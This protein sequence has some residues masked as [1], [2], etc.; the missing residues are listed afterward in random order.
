[1]TLI[2]W[3]W[4]SQRFFSSKFRL[5]CLIRL[6]WHHSVRVIAGN[7][8]RTH[9][10]FSRCATALVFVIW[11]HSLCFLSPGWFISVSDAFPGLD[12][13]PKPFRKV[14]SRV[15]YYTHLEVACYYP[16]IVPHT[17]DSSGLTSV[18]FI[19]QYLVVG[20]VV[21]QKFTWLH[22]C[23]DYSRIISPIQK[24]W[25]SS[26]NSEVLC[27]VSECFFHMLPSVNINFQ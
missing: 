27:L 3:S 11:L 25:L 5:I 26:V 2:F 9:S 16:H 1:M 18:Q 21:N 22:A 7:V 4:S 15:W 12:I 19:V 8:C 10:P 20:N 6:E 24:Y 13:I 14:N 17:T 23:L